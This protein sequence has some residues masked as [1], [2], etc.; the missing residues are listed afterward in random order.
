MSARILVVE[1]DAGLR[2]LLEM[3]LKRHDYDVITAADGAEGLRAFDESKPDMVL[4]DLAMPVIDGWEV[5]RRIREKS[6]I[7]IMM[8][9]AH[10]ISEQDIAEGLNMGADEYMTKPLRDVEFHARINA[11]LRRATMDNHKAPPNSYSD[12]YL[13][14]EINS[15]QVTVDGKEV[16][17]TPTEFNLL[18]LFIQND[19]QVL[20]F[21]DILEQVWGAEYRN[22][23]HYPRIYVSHLRR[24]IEPDFK[25]PTYIHNEYGVGYVFNGRADSK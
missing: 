23:H 22:E 4:L 14:V 7:P 1:D 5:C 2:R 12:D 9:T 25:N 13:V 20:S 15:R 21:Q 17:L 11:L 8:M 19:S 16:R 10:A 24:K 6:N 18:A 3:D